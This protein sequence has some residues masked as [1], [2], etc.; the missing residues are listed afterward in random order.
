[1]SWIEG[2]PTEP[3]DYWFYQTYPGHKTLSRVI[4]GDAALSGNNRLICVAGDFIYAE[5]IDGKLKRVW[6]KPLKLPD[7]PEFDRTCPTCKGERRFSW[8]RCYDCGNTGE[9]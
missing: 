3:G 2:L 5:S 8:N 6:H 1:M 7:P 4:Q 9:I